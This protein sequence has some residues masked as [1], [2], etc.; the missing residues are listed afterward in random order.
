MNFFTNFYPHRRIKV[1]VLLVLSLTFAFSSLTWANTVDV[2]VGDVFYLTG[3]VTDTK[4]DGLAGVSVKEKGTTN[5]INTDANGNFKLK[6]ASGS[7]VLIF[8]YTGFQTK[9]VP[10]NNNTVVNIQLSADS[11]NLTEVV[12]VAYGSQRKSDLTGALTTIK[13][14]DVK[15]QPVTQFAQSIQGKTPGVQVNQTTGIPGQG[16]SIR[17]RGAA[18]FTGSSQPLYVVDGVPLVSD[19]NNLNPSEIETFTIL[20]DA[21]ATALYG[22][23][24]ANGVVIITTKH[25]K[26]GQTNLVFNAF[27]G[28]QTVPQ[29]GRPDMMNAQQFAQY[30]NDVYTQKI[31]MGQATS[32]PVEYQNPS[33]Y[34]GQEGTNWYNI[35]LRNAPIQSYN[36]ALYTGTEKSTTA[37]TL[38]VLNQDGVLIATNY[39]R[40]TARINTDYK[41]NDRLSIGANVA[42][43]YELL[44]NTNTDGNIFGGGI[45]QNAIASSPLVPYKNPDGSLPLTSTAPGLFPNPNWYRVATEQKNNTQKG[46]LLSNAYLNLKLLPGLTYRSTINV[47]YVNEQNQSFN[48]STTG[49]LFNPPPITANGGVYS[50]IYYSWLTENTLN[51]VHSFKGG[52]NLEVLAGYTAQKYHQNYNSQ[53]AYGYP[54]DAIASLAAATQFNTPY[55]DIEEWSLAS[56]ISRINYNYK[57]RYL[58][59]A[60]F[61]RDGS[62]RFAPDS[63]YGNFPAVSAGWN[64]SQEP[65]MANAPVVSDLKLRASYGLTGNFNIGNYTYVANT[66]VSNYPFNNTLTPGT[67]IANI[68]NNKLS[69]EKNRQLD[70]GTDFGLFNNRIAV[71]YDYFRKVTTSL[72]FNIAVPRE[73]GFSSISDNI[74]KIQWYGHEFSVTSRNLIGTL[75]WTSNF[76]ISFV[77]NKILDLGIYGNSLPRSDANGPNIEQVGKP[78]GTF[79]G[80]KF[81]GI[82]KNQADFDSSPKYLG[83]DGPSAVGTVKY[84]DINGDGVIDE[85][86]KTIIGNPNPKFTY[87]ITNNFTYKNFDLGISLAGSYGNDIENRT[88]EYIQNLDGVFNVT[89]DVA[90]RWKSPTDPGDGVHPRILV[91]D[92]LARTT[93]S[94]WITKGSFL[95]L[96]NATLGYTIPVNDSNKY[97]KSI[98]VYAS[99]QQLYVFTHYKGANPEVNANG[100]DPINIG[101]DYTS[102]PVPRT[103]SFGVN[104]N[105]K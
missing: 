52:H 89:A 27:Y 64:V 36:L 86:D 74:G 32:I 3:H 19:I 42:P 66:Q 16:I 78:L 63:K 39:K 1:I 51:Y 62:S 8:S 22:S 80:Y 48:P 85:K 5:G 21:S 12:V 83:S 10:V 104:V 46:R 50:N 105:I 40:Y 70:I 14:D 102:Y 68:G 11:K 73:S 82:Y 44:Q 91:G 18:S 103:V 99:G 58:L 47:D 54:N 92:A 56:F 81:I 57:N 29:K 45:I 77:R 60:S 94:R 38:G 34:A 88:L 90:N 13:A 55:Y 2:N 49:G 35:L 33:Q 59:S 41:F 100:N 20:K 37:V 97:I 4:G 31:A 65:F 43:T 9:E 30:E 75:K 69:W 72:L 28:V 7:A 84:A 61:R 71:S 6:V 23:R 17:I 79:Y 25:A 87:G 67:S 95:T 15:D 24:A 76:N 98:R 53:S 101:I 93:N 26:A 96:K